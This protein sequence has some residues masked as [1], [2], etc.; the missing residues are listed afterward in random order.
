MPDDNTFYETEI[1]YKGNPKKCKYCQGIKVPKI[2][3]YCF[4]LYYFKIIISV[5]LWPIQPV[6]FLSFNMQNIIVRKSCLL[7]FGTLT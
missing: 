2:E 3:K 5:F 7:L 6:I 4:D 1:F